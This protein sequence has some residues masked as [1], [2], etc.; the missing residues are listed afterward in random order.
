MVQSFKD[1]IVWQKSFSLVK[2]VYK[3]SEDLPERERFGLISQLQRAAVSIPSN[4]AEGSER[5]TRKDYIQFLRVA[6][7]SSV[8]LETQLLLSEDLYNVNVTEV[9]S[10]LTEVQKMLTAMIK[11][12]N[13]T[14]T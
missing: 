7:G 14:E 13:K 5:G 11:S 10:K 6:L 9:C 1:L 4:I 8:E 3:L 2:S 12:L